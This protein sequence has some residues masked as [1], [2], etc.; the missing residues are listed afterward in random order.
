MI[1]SLVCIVP[2]SILVHMALSDPG[3][4]AYFYLWDN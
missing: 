3:S 1:S 2:V 4:A